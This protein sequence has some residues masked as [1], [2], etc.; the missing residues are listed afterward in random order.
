ML[1]EAIGFEV[2]LRTCRHQISC[3]TSNFPMSDGKFHVRHQICPCPTANFCPTSNL[4]SDIKFPHVRRQIS[5]PSPHV[6]QQ[7]S[8]PT[9]NF[10]MS[11]SNLMSN[12]EKFSSANVDG[13]SVRLAVSFSYVKRFSVLVNAL[14]SFDTH[15]SA[16]RRCPI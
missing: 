5:C 7:I 13:S 3:P 9:S 8:C 12:I 16:S 10:P 4:P 1:E 14:N 15:Y 2:R 6:R 11:D